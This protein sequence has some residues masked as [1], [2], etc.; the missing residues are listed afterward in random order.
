MANKI[1]SSEEFTKIA[2]ECWKKNFKDWQ[3]L[4]DDEIWDIANS[5]GEKKEWDYPVGFARAIEQALKE[6]NGR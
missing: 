5:L 3:G 6:H 2:N 1:I 4:T